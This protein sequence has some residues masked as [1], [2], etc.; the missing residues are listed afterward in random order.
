VNDAR[1]AMVT[2]AGTGIGADAALLLA[3]KGMAVA[4]VG[5][6]REK[7]EEVAAAVS[8]AGGRAAVVPADLAEPDAPRQVVAATLQELGRIDVLV[9][10]AARIWN[11]PLEVHSIEEF[12]LHYATNVRA[13]FFLAQAALPALR[14]GSHPAI[15]NVSS[16]VG[17]MV[18]P[19]TMLYGS[20]KAALEYLTRAW[21]TSSRPTASGST[22]SRRGPSPRRSTPPTP[23]ISRR[24]T[25]TSPAACRSGGW[26]RCA[27]SRSGSGCSSRRRRRGRRATSS[28]P[29]AARCSG[30]PSRLA[31]ER[32][33]NSS[34]SSAGRA[35]SSTSW[36]GIE[37]ATLGSRVRLESPQ[38][39]ARGGN[40]L[41]IRAF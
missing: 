27:T 7:L 17:S 32:G 37:P 22:A 36:S 9:N 28:T 40:R 1:V 20:S 19:G 4:L 2:G 8:A 18:K 11:G 41:H 38:E 25:P 15:V 6:R 12:D 5:R 35:T 29:T 3:E 23:T 34:S 13:P 26:A 21:R 39:E 33:R 14:R 31:A 10:N 16:S 30:C 24:R